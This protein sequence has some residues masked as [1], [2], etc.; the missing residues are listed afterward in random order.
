MRIGPFV[1]QL[2]WLG[3]PGRFGTALKEIAQ[4]SHGCG[5]DL[6]AVPGEHHP[7]ALGLERRPREDGVLGIPLRGVL[8]HSKRRK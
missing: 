7:H 4:A 5:F 2:G 8:L 6:I 3:V 1:N